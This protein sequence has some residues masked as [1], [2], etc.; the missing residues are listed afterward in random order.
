MTFR[1]WIKSVGVDKISE[2]LGFP[3]ATI[4]SWSRRDDIPQGAWVDIVFKFAEIGLSDLV[5][6]KAASNQAREAASK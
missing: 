2:T 6:M 1:E 3:A 4:Y 5:A